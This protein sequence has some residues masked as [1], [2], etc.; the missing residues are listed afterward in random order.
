MVRRQKKSR[1]EDSR[2]VGMGSALALMALDGGMVGGGPVLGEIA[3]YMGY[4]AMFACIALFTA[5]AIAAFWLASLPV[6]RKAAEQRGTLC[7][8]IG[9]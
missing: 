7:P 2:A 5:G 8:P 3:Y 9:S 6:W 1:P 4:D